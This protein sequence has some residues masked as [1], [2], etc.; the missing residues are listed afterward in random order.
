[1]IFAIFHIL[2]LLQ[3]VVVQKL[4]ILVQ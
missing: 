4:E 2:V 3:V 1:M